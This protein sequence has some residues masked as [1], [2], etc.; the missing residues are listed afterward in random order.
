MNI[1]KIFSTFQRVTILE[2]IIYSDSLV[3]VNITAKDLRLSKG[4]I[5]KFFNLLVSEKILK[6]RRTKF[7]VLDNSFVRAIKILLNINNINPSIFKKYSFIEAL[8]IFGSCTKGTNKEDSDIDLWIKV[9]KTKEAELSELT[10]VLKRKSERIKP[11]FLTKE[12]IEALKKEDTVFY[13]SLVF[14][15]IIIYG[16]EIEF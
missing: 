6:K 11:L 4:L 15:S 10:N 1:N 7:I 9:K 12:K 3:S 13:H 14:G 2:K 16:E 5:S 8:G